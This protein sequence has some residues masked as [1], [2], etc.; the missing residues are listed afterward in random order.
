[1]LKARSIFA[2]PFS[3]FVL[4]AAAVLSGCGGGGGGGDVGVSATSVCDRARACGSLSEAGYNACVA[5]GE[6][7]Q[8]EADAAGC[9]AEFQALVECGV[10]EG[11][12]SNGQFSAQGVC[13]VEY[14]T[15]K[16]CTGSAGSPN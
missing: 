5:D 15:F 3:S 10:N 11:I 9:S 7:T 1:M 8:S 4:I 16:A 2:L 6:H 13:D 14:G 12:C